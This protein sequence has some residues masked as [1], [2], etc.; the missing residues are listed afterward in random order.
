MMR[1]PDPHRRTGG[2]LLLGDFLQGVMSAGGYLPVQYVYAY[3]VKLST[4]LQLKHNSSWDGNVLWVVAEVWTH[5]K[6]LR[7]V[8]TINRNE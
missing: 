8:A 7:S 4:Q 6:S 1:G 3:I 2:G 5:H